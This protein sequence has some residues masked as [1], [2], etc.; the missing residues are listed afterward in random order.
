MGTILCKIKCHQRR[1]FIRKREREIMLHAQIKK[2]F[3]TL[4]DI[5]T[6]LYFFIRIIKKRITCFETQS[7]IVGKIFEFICVAIYVNN[8]HLYTSQSIKIISAIQRITKNALSFAMHYIL[9]YLC[10]TNNSQYTKIQLIQK[11]L[12]TVQDTL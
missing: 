3:Q 12:N 10:S 4:P 11:M 1:Q 7:S 5:L 8:R 6:Q 2:R 9:F